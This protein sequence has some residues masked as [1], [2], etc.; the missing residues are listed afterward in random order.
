MY[1]RGKA[2]SSDLRERIIAACQV[3]E[4]SQGK[5]AQRFM[6]SRVFVNRLFNRFKRTGS[7]APRA[8]GGGNPGK[9]HEPERELM[10][11]WLKNQPDLT[12]S[13]LRERLV[14]HGGVDVDESTISRHLI[15]MG[16]SRKKRVPRS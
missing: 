5:I 2:I 10:R 11:G 12:C 7:S 9:I 4:E 15:D 6:V 16:L 1:A 8:R 14:E 3:G 13:E